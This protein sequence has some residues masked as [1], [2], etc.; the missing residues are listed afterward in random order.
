MYYPEAIRRHFTEFIR[1]N[2]VDCYRVPY[3]LLLKEYLATEHI[4]LFATIPSL[5][6]HIGTV[7][8][9]LGVF[10]KAGQFREVI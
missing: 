1:S 7:S 6:E 4:P 2:G 10:H 8:T 5:V 3:D 9:G